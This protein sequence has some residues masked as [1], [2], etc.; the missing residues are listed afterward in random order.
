[1]KHIQPFLLVCM[2]CPRLTSIKQSDD[3]IGFIYIDFGMFC[4]PVIGPYTFCEPGECQG[5]LFN[6]LIELNVEGDTAYDGRPQVHKFT[7]DL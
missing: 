7:N 6:S 5:G 3:D 4:Q 2:H 1:M